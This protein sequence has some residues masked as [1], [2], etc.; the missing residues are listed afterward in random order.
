MN[1]IKREFS[2]PRTPQQNGIAVRK[3]RTLIEAARTML[4]DSLIP[5]PFWAEAVNI[6][7]YVQNRVLVTKPHNKTPYEL[8]LGRT[9]SIGF[10]RPF[11]CPV[12][13]LNSLDPLGKFDGN[14]DEGFFVGYSVSNKAGEGNVQQYVLFPLWS[15]GSKDPYNTDDDVTFEVKEPESEVYVSPSSSTKTKKHDDKTKRMAKGK[16]P[17]DSSTGFQILSEEFEDFTDNSINED[18]NGNNTYRMFTLVSAAGSSYVNLGGSI[19]VNA[20]TLPNPDL[21]TTP[22]MPDLEDTT[23]LQDTG[24]FSGAMMKLRV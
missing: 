21:P 12:T 14:A 24:I 19:P 6:V 20:D 22:L 2:V 23:D 13:I 9:P 11:G 7:C 16:S 4:A 15:S 5:I 3:N 1:G 18:A 8:L 10:M 17:V